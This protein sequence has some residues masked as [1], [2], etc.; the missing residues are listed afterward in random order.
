[1]QVVG[2][3]GVDKRTD[4][5]AAAIRAKM[6]VRDLE[7][8]ELAY[9]PPFGSAKDPVNMVGFVA[10]NV[11][12]G[13]VRQAF[14][15]EFAF[16]LDGSRVILDVR[17]KAEWDEGHVPGAVHFPLGKLRS[18]LSELQKGKRY[19]TYCGVGIRSYTASRI[20][21]QNGFDVHNI[22]GGY[23]SFRYFHPEVVGG[24]G[25][26]ASFLELQ[27]RFCEPYVP[28]RASEPPR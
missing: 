25:T 17:T 2:G 9:A 3:K 22:A 4:V 16:P 13:V 15:D 10:G 23:R 18:K 5:F 24:A 7:D 21:A 8:L 14:W 20:L 26:R 12:S 11:L 27:E 19:Y 6:S 28:D 1:V